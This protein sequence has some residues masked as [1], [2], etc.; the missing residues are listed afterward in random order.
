MQSTLPASR[1][2][3]TSR[4]GLPI[5][6]EA[7]RIRVSRT[8]ATMHRAWSGSS[9]TVNSCGLAPEVRS[10]QTFLGK[11][12][13][14]QIDDA[15]GRSDEDRLASN[16]RSSVMMLTAAKI[17]SGKR[18]CAHIQNCGSNCAFGYVR[19]HRADMWPSTELGGF[20]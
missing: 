16:D 14:R 1:Y 2:G 8:R 3:S 9:R 10:V 7:Y 18:E 20:P 4:T 5:Y 15:V 12:L 11:A 19:R 17:G 13:L 6:F